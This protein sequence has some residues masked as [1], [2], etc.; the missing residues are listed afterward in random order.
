[1]SLWQIVL[2]IIVVLL[3]IM[4]ILYLVG[5]KMQSKMDDQKSMIDQHKTT[6][7]ILVIDKKKLKPKDANLSKMIYDQLPKYLR[8][9]K[10]PMVK[11]KIGPK[12][13]TLLCDD[14]IF[15]DL[16]VK[17]M[18]KVEIAGMYIVGYKGS[19]K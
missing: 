6:T 12:I 9:R 8:F 11:A 14:K 15:N 5:R 1:M 7:S 2:I 4:G 19:K 3:S 13:T 17:K 10:L 16:P 18:V